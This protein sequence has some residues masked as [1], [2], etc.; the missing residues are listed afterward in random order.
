[1]SDKPRIEP[2]HEPA[3]GWGATAA[4]FEHLI[5]QGIL[6][7]GTLALLRMNTEIDVRHVLP[8]VRVPTLV[9]HRTGDVQDGE[10]Q[11]P[12]DGPCRQRGRAWSSGR[13]S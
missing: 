3:G 8:A 11:R 6:T 5:E 1:M 10:S 2:Y 7:K 9:L 12:V 13:S 4:T